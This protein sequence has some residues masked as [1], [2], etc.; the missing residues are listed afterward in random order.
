MW[1]ELRTS[2][3]KFVDVHCTSDTFLLLVPVFIPDHMTACN[4]TLPQPWVVAIAAHYGQILSLMVAEM[5]FPTIARPDLAPPLLNLTPGRYSIPATRRST[6]YIPSSDDKSNPSTGPDLLPIS[7]VAALISSGGL[8]SPVIDPGCF[9]LWFDLHRVDT[10]C[11]YHRAATQ[12][13]FSM[14]FN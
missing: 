3:R 10:W 12:I 11:L 1:L 8:C 2:G 4:L 14:K 9:L 6:P 13:A 5:Y 7:C